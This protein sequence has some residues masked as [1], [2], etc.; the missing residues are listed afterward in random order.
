MDITRVSLVDKGANERRLAVMKRQ[1][2]SMG[3]TAVGAAEA[4]PAG[5]AAWLRK[6]ADA[7]I[8]RVP[9]AKVQTFASMVAGQELQE[10]LGESWWTLQ[11]A[12]WAAIYA[13]DDNGADLSLE[14][15]QALV[16]QDLD[17]FKA[18]LLAEMTEATSIGKRAT[19]PDAAAIAA[20]V[21]KVGRKISGSRL[22]RLQS[23]ADALSSVLTEVEDS[24]EADDTEED[25][26]VDKAEITKAITDGLAAGLEPITKRLDALETGKVEKTEG[27]GDDAPI[28]LEVIA[29]AVGKVADR[30]TAIETAGAVGKRTSVVGQ[31]GGEVKKRTTFAGIF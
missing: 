12:L 20:F 4:G 28:T 1:E 30:L 7:V 29:E 6:A 14:A 17:E 10:A 22:E 13:T 23:A 26:D 31:D 25:T 15:K 2:A 21:A 5:I 24:N 8:G 3:N 27:E 18:Y 11:D 9:V 19:N 16:G